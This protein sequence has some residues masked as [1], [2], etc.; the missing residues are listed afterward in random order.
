MGSDEFIARTPIVGRDHE[1]AVLNAFV[2]EVCARGSTLLLTG[3]PGIG[4]ST[5]LAAAVDMASSASMR[6][7]HISCTELT[8]RA[9]FA[10]LDELRAGLSADLGRLS[11]SHRHAL[12]VAL[13]L[14]EGQT[15][16]VLV[17]ANATLELLRATPSTLVII[18]DLH[19]LDRASAEVLAAVARR[20][21]GTMIGFIGASRPPLPQFFATAGLPEHQLAPLRDKAAAALARDACPALADPALKRVLAEAR[22]NPLALV[23]LP[24]SLSAPQASALA[25]LPPV[26]P[27]TQRLVAAFA[28]GLRDLPG[29]TR[30]VLL[31]AALEDR[32]ELRTLG[33]AARELGGLDQ[34]APAEEAGLIIVDGN[35]RTVTFRHP[36]VRAAVVDQ[37]TEIQQRRAHR[38][39]ANV[40]MD[41]P[42]RRAWHLAS[43]CVDVDEDVA[44]LLEAVGRS[45]AQGGDALGATAALTRAAELSVTRTDQS[46]RLINAA[47]I[48]AVV[49]GQMR[50]ARRLLV[51]AHDA[52]PEASASLRAATVAANLLFNSECD[53]GPAHR[54]LTA[55]LLRYAQ[56]Y[57]AGDETAIDALHSLLMVCWYSGSRE[58]WES[59][60]SL[61][62]RVAPQPL[63]LLG[64]SASLMRGAEYPARPWLDE[65][66]SA[67]G[68]LHREFDPV[69]IIRTAIASI[70]VDRVGACREALWRVIR[71]GREA[72]AVALSVSALV[73]ICVDDWS[74]GQWDE[75][76]QLA[77]EGF[78]LSVRHGYQCFSP[79]FNGYLRSLIGAARGDSRA[80][81]DVEEMAAWA[82][83][84]GVGVATT[85]AH[86]VRAL[87]AV[88]RGDFEAAYQH[89]TAISPAGVTARYTPHALWVMLDAVESAVRTGRI[90]EA[91]AH[92]AAMRKAN[93][94]EL[95]PRLALIVAGAA[96]IAADG[97]EATRLYRESLA[98]PEGERWP[99]DLARVMLCFGEHL[100]RQKN[101]VESR[102]NLWAAADIF[103]RL[104]AKP[105]AIRAH[106]ELRATGLPQAAPEQLNAATLTPEDL[107][108]AHLAASGLSNRQIA[109][110]LYVSHRTVGSRLYRLFPK[111]G[112]TTRAGLRD[113]LDAM[114]PSATT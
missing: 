77:Q 74:S 89:A 52:A 70:Y 33:R 81:T 113:A 34:L 66:D 32:G 102:A 47:Y 11:A 14:A 2:E 104:G 26:L 62:A 23:E 103:E 94:A 38:R 87:S 65:L 92:V 83:Q 5:L 82:D 46:R 68:A 21:S 49:T 99:F 100:R 27:V 9:S 60:E 4:K 98:V 108:V 3:Q 58:A 72:G 73:S 51:A 84:Q 76:L 111:L 40:L 93:I 63:A 35:S 13:G 8:H 90:A 36:T 31:L 1:L 112:I 43:A 12:T 18:D 42:E 101:L 96:A 37:S 59:F 20:L 64:I 28:S 95:S 16:H 22:G 6:V 57:D 17:L 86:H 91:G 24:A 19:L 97:E 50:H 80:L 105:W 10:A 75:A 45:R 114:S 67:V 71:D 39:L 30:E 79:I 41:Q 44:K 85:F 48:H 106:Q 78:Q 55:A 29:S 107:E 61:L 7:V 88:G 54:L 109:Q 56:S 110:R 69:I 15:P 53:V 25:A